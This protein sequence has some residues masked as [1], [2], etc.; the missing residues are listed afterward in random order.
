MDI[1]ENKWTVIKVVFIA[2]GVLCTPTMTGKNGDFPPLWVPFIGLPFF[3][4]FLPA[5]SSGIAGIPGRKLTRPS[6]RASPLHPFFDPLPFYHLAGWAGVI[7]GTAQV[8]YASLIAHRSL[9][10]PL[11]FVSAGLGALIGVH[12]AQRRLKDKLVEWG[13]ASTPENG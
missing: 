8:L 9:F 6:W 10:E 5:Y 11:F 1:R 2:V 13:Q 3:A 12:V 4:I 7:C